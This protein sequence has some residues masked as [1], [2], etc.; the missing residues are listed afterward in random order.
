M[1]AGLMAAA[2]LLLLFLVRRF[3][4]LRYRRQALRRLTDLEQAHEIAANSLL[5]ELSALL[6]RAAL[7]AYPDETC[8]GLNGEDWLRFLDRP[9]KESPFSQGVGRCLATGPYQKT[10]DFDRAALLALCRRYLRR[11]PPPRLRRTP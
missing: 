7:C 8:A 9:L 2:A 11:L 6:R 4:R 1:V 5:A 10:A 3:R